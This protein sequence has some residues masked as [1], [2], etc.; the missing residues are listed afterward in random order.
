M[1][2][3]PESSIAE[4]NNETVDLELPR[5]ERTKKFWRN[6]ADIPVFG[7]FFAYSFSG[8]FFRVFLLTLRIIIYKYLL[9]MR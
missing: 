1:E 5:S 9:I 8:I 7:F 2:N 6:L 3:A 4:A